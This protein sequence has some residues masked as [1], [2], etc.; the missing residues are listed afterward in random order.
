MSLPFQ[1]GNRVVGILLSNV[2]TFWPIVT[3]FLSNQQY[4]SGATYMCKALL[5]VPPISK[6]RALFGVFFAVSVKRL[7]R[8]L[9]NL[10]SLEIII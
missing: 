1:N 7:D 2:Q 3:Q 6:W 5:N 8:L 10:N 9:L 4:K